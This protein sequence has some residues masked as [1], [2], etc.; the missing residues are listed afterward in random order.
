MIVVG[1]E[2]RRVQRHAVHGQPA[3]ALL[4]AGQPV[5]AGPVEADR[6]V[7]PAV[8]D[9]AHRPGERGSRTNLDEGASKDGPSCSST[10]TW[11]FVPPKPKL[12]TDARRGVAEIHG[13]TAVFR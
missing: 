10:V 2:R 7:R 13:R 12:D 8:Q 9:A 3:E 4:E 1:R 5:P 6:D 11:K